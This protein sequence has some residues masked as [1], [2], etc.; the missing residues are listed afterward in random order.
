[1]ESKIQLSLKDVIFI[2]S[3]LV[4]WAGQWFSQ[5]ARVRELELKMEAAAQINA[6]KIA[7]LETAFAKMDA[8]ATQA[9]Q[10]QKGRK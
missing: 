3:M 7:A 2:G 4:S 10:P 6:L 5:T 8:Q 9:V 1:M